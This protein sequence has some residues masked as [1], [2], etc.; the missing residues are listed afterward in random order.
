MKLTL[1]GFSLFLFAAWGLAGL[2]QAGQQLYLSESPN[3]KYRVIIEQILDRRVGDKFF[4]RYSL[5]L[6][7][8]RNSKHHFEVLQGGSPLVHETDKGTFQIYS[9]PE[10]VTNANDQ[11][12]D[13]WKSIRFA[14]S[15]DS[16]KL[17][18]RLEV[19]EGSWKTYFV[20][21]NSG[22]TLDITGDLETALV[23]KM[24]SRKWACEEPKVELVTWTKPYLAFFKLTSVCGKEREESNNKLFY[25]RDSVL[26]DTLQAKAVSHCKNCE[27]KKALKSFD[28]YFLSTIPTPTPMPTP[29]PTPEETPTA[30]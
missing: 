4:F 23:D 24:D 2:V 3:G 14:W 27:D 6:L 28:K 12:D 30:Q 19:I 17:F 9:E 7:N 11:F 22:K 13:V 26:F 15:K 10:P 25:L 16:L 5:D 21:I 8:T 29:T 20:D 18:I 1:K